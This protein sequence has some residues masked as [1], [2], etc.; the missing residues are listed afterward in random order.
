MAKTRVISSATKKEQKVPMV[1]ATTK[2]EAE[3][4]AKEEKIVL[5]ESTPRIESQDRWPGRTLAMD[6]EFKLI[7]MTNAI[8]ILPHNL[9]IKGRHKKENIQAICG[10]I[11]TDEMVDLVYTN[12][13]HDDNED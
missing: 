1:E 12:F 6:D 2:K 7:S 4:I 8:K 3:P 11:V 5:V 9:I 13:S 10:F